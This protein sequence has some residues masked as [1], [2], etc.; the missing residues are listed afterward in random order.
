M[1]LNG[2]S[3][4][5]GL[6]PLVNASGGPLNDIVVPYSEAGKAQ[7]TGFHAKSPEEY[8]MV[9]EDIFVRSSVEDL[10]AIRERARASALQRFANQEFEK[11]WS[12]FWGAL[13]DRSELKKSRGQ[14]GSKKD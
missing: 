13:S 2:V 5:A 10:A 14:K 1:Q 11:G 9:L 7:P 3:Q 4:A 12:E 8:A 6:I